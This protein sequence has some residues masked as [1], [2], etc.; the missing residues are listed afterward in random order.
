M[1][2]NFMNEPVDNHGIAYAQYDYK[3]RKDY[4]HCPYCGK[5]Q[6]SVSES[7]RIKYLTWKCKN[8]KCKMEFEVNV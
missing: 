8:S 6:I 5:K 2:E 7:T 1:P 4:I 3:T